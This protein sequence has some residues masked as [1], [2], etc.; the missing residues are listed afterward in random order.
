MQIS[1]SE[2][3]S[4]KNKNWSPCLKRKCKMFRMV[5]RIYYF[6]SKYKSLMPENAFKR[7]TKKVSK[8]NTLF[9]NT[10]KHLIILQLTKTTSIGLLRYM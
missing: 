7:R 9:A 4:K 3:F 8:P 5:S 10:T 6:F 1:T 2:K